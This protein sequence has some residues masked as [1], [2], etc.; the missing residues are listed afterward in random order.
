MA[1]ATPGRLQ[2]GGGPCWGGGYSGIRFHQAGTN[3]PEWKSGCPGGRGLSRGAG[4]P[5]QVQRGR[6]RTPRART[7]LPAP[8]P[9]PLRTARLPRAWRAHRLQ[10]LFSPIFTA[11]H[12][13]N[14]LVAPRVAL[15]VSSELFF[16]F[17][18][19][20]EGKASKLFFSSLTLRSRKYPSGILP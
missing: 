14:S 18:F 13:K 11:G 19:L 10:R 2:G 16:Y 5:S 20:R 9:H 12:L 17:I 3:P 7:P 8:L 6:A 4:M 1:G 15:F